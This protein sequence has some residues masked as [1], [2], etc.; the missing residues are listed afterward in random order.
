LLAHD[1]K[2]QQLI[3]Q[4]GAGASG[5]IGARI[6]GN[7]NLAQV[8]VVAGDAFFVNFDDA[9]HQNPLKDVADMMCAFND[10]AALAIR[11]AQTTDAS[12]NSDEIHRLVVAYTHDASTAFYGAYQ[13]ATAALAQHWPQP[14]NAAAALAL[15]CIDNRAREIIKAEHRPDWMDVPLQ[16]LID[17]I[18]EHQ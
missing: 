1:E 7:L 2:I 5:G 17:M 9:S 16:G 6:H 3:A 8:L 14:G 10:A 18:R 11:N 4:L 13:K 15:F 12:S